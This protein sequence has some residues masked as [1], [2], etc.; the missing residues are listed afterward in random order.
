MSKM[1]RAFGLLWV[2]LCAVVVVSGP[3]V[4]SAAESGW[5]IQSLPTPAVA[6]NGQLTGVSCATITDCIAV[7]VAQD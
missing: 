1:R 5:T 2:A 7:G 4:A 6:P 3:M